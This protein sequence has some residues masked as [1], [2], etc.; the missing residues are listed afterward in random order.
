MAGRR[1][2][3]RRA[4]FLD[5]VIKKRAG[6]PPRKVTRL[7]GPYREYWGI[8]SFSPRLQVFW[9]FYRRSGAGRGHRSKTRKTGDTPLARAFSSYRVA[10]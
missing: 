5:L 6:G 2:T 3:R 10:G 7:L 8:Y 1:I 9:G 4:R